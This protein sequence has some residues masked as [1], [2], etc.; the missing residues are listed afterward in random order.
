MIY[1]VAML[2]TNLHCF[3]Y[4]NC[5]VGSVPGAEQAL[6]KMSVDAYLA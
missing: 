2:L 1:P 3:F 4:G 5:I 6:S